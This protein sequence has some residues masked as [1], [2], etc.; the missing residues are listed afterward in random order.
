M[1]LLLSCVT[2]EGWIFMVGLRVFDL[3]ALIVWLVWFFRHRE[4]DDDGDDD[5]DWRRDAPDEP[6][7]SPTGPGGLELPLP[8][9]EQARRRVRDH[10][11]ERPAATP[12]ARRQLPEPAPTRVPAEPTH[13]PAR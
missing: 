10:T 4:D 5:R 11:G 3:G 13:R 12:P 2:L 1:R 8:E 9:A 6:P 7:P